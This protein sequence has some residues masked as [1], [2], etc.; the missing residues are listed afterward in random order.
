MADEDVRRREAGRAKKAVQIGSDGIAPTLS[1]GAVA[2]TVAGAV[3]PACAVGL[4]D[5]LLNE[6][7][8]VARLAVAALEHDGRRPVA[9]T[10]EV[11]RALADAYHATDSREPLGVAPLADSH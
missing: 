8:R 11:E 3:V 1:L 4:R 6:N 5:L 7:P 2:P 10:I 9:H